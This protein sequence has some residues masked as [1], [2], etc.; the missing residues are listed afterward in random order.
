MRDE[1]NGFGE[2]DKETEEEMML[3][4]LVYAAVAIPAAILFVNRYGSVHWP[5]IWM[6]LFFLALD[7][8]S[9]LVSAYLKGFFS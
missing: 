8:A 3:S 9:V 4:F 5:T 2:A 7:D 1:G 6:A